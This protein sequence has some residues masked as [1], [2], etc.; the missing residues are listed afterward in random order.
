M[1]AL[2]L[3]WPL[4]QSGYAVGDCECRGLIGSDAHDDF[5]RP[6]SGAPRSEVQ[7]FKLQELALV[8]TLAG[9]CNHTTVRPSSSPSLHLV[10]YGRRRGTGECPV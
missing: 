1:R 4:I 5:R 8:D 2:M 7:V 9:E 3:D 10:F 6:A